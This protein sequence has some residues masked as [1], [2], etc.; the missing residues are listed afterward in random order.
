MTQTNRLAVMIDGEVVPADAPVRVTMD[1]GLIRGDG[2]FEGMRF[3]GR[4]PRTPDAHL[5]RL[6]KSG[7]GA[8]ISIDT[9]LLRQEMAAF[10]D[11]TVTPDCGVR[12]I[13][14]RS[15][16]RIWREEPIPAWSPEGIGLLPVAHRVTP[17]LVGVKT[18]SYSANMRAQRM[19]NDQGMNDAL[20]YRADD[21]VILE[22]PTTS[23]AWLEGDTLVFPPLE[24]G[25]LDSITRRVATEAVP[26]IEREMTLDGLAKADGAFLLS[27][28][29]E[30]VPVHTVLGIATFAVDTP[31]VRDV[32]EAVSAAILA[33]VEAVSAAAGR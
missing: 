10:C 28:Y 18:L 9:D 2:V 31:R 33:R 1:D 23:F 22:G 7:A 4:R 19:A 30:A 13:V 32:V 15:G 12:L 6:A 20:L 29:Q 24:A 14:T 27:S 17:L 5:E 11:A 25:V 26:A 16:I 8:G 21:R 3:Y